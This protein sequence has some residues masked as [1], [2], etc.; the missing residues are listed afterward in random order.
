[1]GMEVILHLSRE[2]A[3]AK[4]GKKRE[5]VTVTANHRSILN[6]FY[7]NFFYLLYELWRHVF[8]HMQMQGWFQL[9]WLL[10]STFSPFVVK[11]HGPYSNKTPKI[12]E[13]YLRTQNTT[14]YL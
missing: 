1:M 12:F 10:I 8:A 14:N 13:S 3:A 11:E 5:E 4:M 6:I 2:G 9:S 7:D